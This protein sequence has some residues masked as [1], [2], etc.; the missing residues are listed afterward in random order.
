MPAIDYACEKCGQTISVRLGERFVYC[1]HCGTE[2]KW[3]DGNVAEVAAP[4][5]ELQPDDY[6][7]SPT[8]RPLPREG[9]ATAG[10]I[11]PIPESLNLHD[12]GQR[13]TIRRRWFTPAVFFLIFFCIAWDSFLVFWYSMALGGNGPP[14]A[15]G[16]IFILFP[17][18]HVAVGVGLTYFCIASLF[19]TTKISVDRQELTVTHGPIPWAGNRRIPSLSVRQ[20]Y[21]TDKTHG[22]TNN[23]NHRVPT[24]S[25][26]VNAVDEHGRK[27]KL[28]KIEK[29]DEALSIERLIE[30]YLDLPDDSVAGEVE[31]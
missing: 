26:E 22:R 27:I 17:I 23:S 16:L 28:A 3:P 29:L 31:R 9:Q 19:N 24:I 8:G 12:D 10:S 21:V 14:G 4:D 15:F 6:V 25:Y 1:R 13:L 18:A 2:Q 20:L 11:V 7:E 30:Q 5:D